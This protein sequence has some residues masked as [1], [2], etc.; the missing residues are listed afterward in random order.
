M[1]LKRWWLFP[2][3]LV[4]LFT[5]AKS[6]VD[7]PILGSRRL[8]RLGLHAWRVR[9]A[10]DMAH[11][12]RTKLS[13][14]VDPEF[15]SQFDESGFVMVKDWLPA[16][17]FNN[18]RTALF[19]LETSC[20]AHQQGDTVTVRVPLSRKLFRQVPALRTILEERRWRALMSYVASSGVRPLYYLQA[21]EGGALAG[22][23]DPQ[24][25]LHA[26]TFQPSMKAWLF[27]TDVR[28][29]DRPLK[30]VPGS[31]KL[32]PERLAWERERSIDVARSG[33]R[34][35]QRGSFRIPEDHLGNLGLPE[36]MSFCVPANTLVVVDTCG[37]HAR[38]ASSHTSLRVELWALQRRQPFL[39][40]SGRSY[41]PLSVDGRAD[42]LLSLADLLDQLGLRKQHWRRA[43]SW[44]R[45]LISCRQGKTG[46]R[47]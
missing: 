23:P 28:E 44:S 45:R 24:H 14:S 37:F 46:S 38:A 33:D 31:H 13:K 10:H 43:G 17:T 25:D 30:Y 1:L 20:R 29:E 18:L 40:W 4:A 32:T 15:R 11:L 21:I 42:W 41:L 36:P 39:P 26:D 22:P 35:S 19:D 47:Q 9:L 3:W 12:R 8:N 2:I 7:N 5:G 6:F 27:L 34:L 16:S